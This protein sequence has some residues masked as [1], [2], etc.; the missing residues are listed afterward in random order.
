M[1]QNQRTYLVT[2]AA[3]FAGGGLVRHL[4]D[5]GI[6]VRGMVRRDA[7]ADGIRALGAEAVIADLLDAGSLARAVAGVDGVYHIAALFRQAGFPDEV[8][9]DV[10][11]LGTRRLL[12]A[13][14]GAGVRRF[15]HC[16]TVGVLGHIANPPADE[17]TPYNPGDVYQRTKMEGETIALETFR[18]GAVP[19]VVIR[20]AMI[21]GPG[22]AR[23]LKLFRMIARRRFF[24]VGKGQATVHWIDVRDLAR[25]FRLAME[26][27][28]INGEVYII[29]GKTSVTLEAMCRE[30]A[31]QL[32]V[33]P[34]WLRLPVRPVQWAGSLCETLCRPL[35][36]EPPLYR[37]RVDFFTKSRD[38]NASKARRDLSF[39]P[40]QDFPAEIADIIRSYREAG[41]I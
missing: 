9:H 14:I 39:E 19:G 13:S 38:F 11:A 23:T 2:G 4:L 10:N 34:P 27:D 18:S 17:D 41:Q 29:A 6:H 20:P 5:A 12:D 36:V 15:V 30:V 26:H 40:A 1:Q 7:Q 8:F 31:R 22:D 37:R 33:P 16:S 35:G 21:Y 28:T 25:A 24:Y 3:G 32:G